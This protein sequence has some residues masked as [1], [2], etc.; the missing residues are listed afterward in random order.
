MWNSGDLRGMN[1]R[2]AIIRLSLRVS[3]GLLDPSLWGVQVTH[4]LE[5]EKMLERD[6]E[7]HSDAISQVMEDDVA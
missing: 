3:R 4:H 6:N 7:V 5:D 2:W 1:T